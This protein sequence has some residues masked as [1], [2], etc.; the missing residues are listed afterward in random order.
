M[1]PTRIIS[2]SGQPAVTVIQSGYDSISHLSFDDVVVDDSHAAYPTLVQ[3]AVLL[4]AAERPKAEYYV[5]LY[6]HVSTFQ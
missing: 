6:D 4:L 2:C 5:G 1:R 3:L